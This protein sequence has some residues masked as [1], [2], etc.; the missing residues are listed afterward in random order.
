MSKDKKNLKNKITS[1]LLILAIVLATIFVLLAI[2]SDIRNNFINIITQQNKS[3]QEE[4]Q[5]TTEQEIN[6]RASQIGEIGKISS[7]TIRETITG[8][9][10]WDANDE[11]GNDSSPTNNIVR[12]FD[13]VTW[14]VDL[15][16]ALK[17]GTIENG[18]TGGIIEVE[19]EIPEECA[20]VMSWETDSM[21]WME[22]AQLS[23]D[24]TKITGK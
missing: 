9:G 19:A 5:K 18:L 12:S 17:E 14:T 8:T 23:T 10:P 24:G 3:N 16:M 13:Q 22:N 20:N 6:D 4:M 7:A 15:T 1:K 21:L 11:P 2:N